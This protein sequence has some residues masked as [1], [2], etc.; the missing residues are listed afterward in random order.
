[1]ASSTILNKAITLTAAGILLATGVAVDAG[2]VAYWRFEEGP[3]GDVQAPGY[4]NPADANILDSSGNNFRLQTFHNGFYG[5][6]PG[7]FTTAPAYRTDVPV[8]TVPGTGAANNLYMNFNPRS[9]GE[10]YDIYTSPGTGSGLDG[11]V[12][13]QIT[14]EA[15]V[16][17]L[18]TGGYQTFIGKDGSNFPN[19]DPP[20]AGLYFQLVGGEGQDR[21]IKFATHQGDGAFRQVFSKNEVTP[22][23]WYNFAGVTDGSTMKLYTKRVDQA[24]WTLDAEVPF[25]GGLFTQNRTWTLGRGMYNE[26]LVDF[27]R[28]SLDE[29]RISDSALD[30]S[31]F[32]F[33]GVVA[34]PAPATPV[35][36]PAARLSYGF[37]GSGANSGTLGNA[38]DGSLGGTASYQSGT[39]NAAVGQ[40]SVAIGTGPNDDARFTTPQVNVGG[41][42][43]DGDFTYSAW[44]KAGDSPTLQM[45]AANAET[46]PFSG[47][48]FYI[49]GS[50]QL[51]V[52]TGNGAGVTGSSS[53][54]GVVPN[55]GQYHHVSFIFDRVGDGFGNSY[56]RVFV[57]G[58]DVTANVV[59]IGG[60]NTDAPVDFGQ[61]FPNP[62]D[63][64]E[65]FTL[66]GSIDQ[67]EFYGGQLSPAQLKILGAA[68]W[69]NDVDGEW[70][71]ASF[72]GGATD[73]SDVAVRFG[74]RNTDARTVTLNTARTA[75]YVIFDSA[76][77]YDIA[78]PSTLTIDGPNGAVIQATAGS[79]TISAP[80]NLETGTTIDVASGASITTSGAITAGDPTVAVAKTGEGTWNANSAA[81][82]AGGLTVAG[83]TVVVGHASGLGTGPVAVEAGAGIELASG[84]TDAVSV[85]SLDLDPAAS[86]NV[87]DGIVAVGY[88]G[89]SVLSDLASLIGSGAIAA[90]SGLVV[91]IA[92]A[93]DPVLGLD[94]TG[95]TALYN[96]ATIDDTTVILRGTLAGDSDLD[97][98]V[99]FDDL[100]ILLGNYDS[101]AGYTG[102]DTANDGDVDFDD[103][104]QLLGN[105]DSV[106]GTLSLAPG[107]LD[108][109]AVSLLEAHGFTVAVPEPTALALVAPAAMLLARRRRVA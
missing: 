102:G 3:E 19:S 11:Y 5:G 109:A 50:R 22:G 67:A 81:S 31:Q 95:G 20:L 93:T 61:Q 21:K 42:D 68:R 27:F 26:S 15:T 101:V 53:N 28:G 73:G 88:T 58:V 54:A 29:V 64:P 4:G 18:D 77:S 100:G 51:V 76:S 55:D 86:L 89:T 82:F 33:P 1:M 40:S 48:K 16:R 49:S 106:V 10:R 24:N 96:G 90:G 97:A 14:I 12:F 78:G 80:V 23:V 105:Y 43:S 17:F 46:F 91:G 30:P 35:S 44:V 2:T 36:L 63:P 84:L 74:D 70:T 103:L 57:D 8:S 59:P 65:R 108:A 37:E 45:I 94:F 47:F 98:D 56:T 13:N 69:A 107:L 75:G 9:P 39:G 6:G 38:F 92:E 85:T 72:N 104:G 7:D 60:V 87:A 62:L 52:E 71:D 66:N 32:L 79:H 99:D 34:R 25:T 41:P 83:G